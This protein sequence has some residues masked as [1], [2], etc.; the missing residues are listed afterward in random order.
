MSSK[1]GKGKHDHYT[2]LFSFI[3]IFEWKSSSQST[4]HSSKRIYRGLL[5]CRETAVLW[6]GFLYFLFFLPKKTDSWQHCSV[7]KLP[8]FSSWMKILEFFLIY[9]ISSRQIENVM[10]IFLKSHFIQ[11]S[12]WHFQVFITR[13]SGN[14]FWAVPNT[15]VF[16]TI[17]ERGSA[18]GSTQFF[19]EGLI[20][21][22]HSICS[23]PSS[24]HLMTRN[25]SFYSVHVSL[26]SDTIR[27]FFHA[28]K[29]VI[30]I[31]RFLATVWEKIKA[32]L[33][34]SI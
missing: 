33:Y 13:L 32:N 1:L 4:E 3:Q 20:P 6:I 25:S 21:L 2:K 18:K 30:K 9:I 24:I 17:P 22:N 5:I 16:N 12:N 19:T 11:V 14:H 26:S 8:L 29:L 23:I 31:T 15:I 10:K 27:N 34:E 7:R 28:K